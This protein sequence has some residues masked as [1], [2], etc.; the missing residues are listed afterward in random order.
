MTEGELLPP[1]LAGCDPQERLSH[2]P[3]QRLLAAGGKDRPSRLP[4]RLVGMEGGDFIR[5]QRA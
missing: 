1:V 5:Q 2:S 4:L 3:E